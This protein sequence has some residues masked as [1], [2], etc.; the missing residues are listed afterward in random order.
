MNELIRP[1]MESRVVIKIGSNSLM[2]PETGKPDYIKIERLA[3]ELTDL[4]NRGLDVCLVSSGAIAIGRQMLMRT[5]KPKNLS[6]KQALASIGQSRLMMIY[7]E[8]S[9]RLSGRY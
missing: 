9:I 6:E 3:M 5:E 8:A 4:R 7:Q 2:H 1:V